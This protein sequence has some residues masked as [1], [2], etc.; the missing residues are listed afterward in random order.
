MPSMPLKGVL[1][2]ILH[3]NPRAEDQARAMNEMRGGDVCAEVH[4]SNKHQP[5][6][7][8]HGHSLML[9]QRRGTRTIHYLEYAHKY[10]LIPSVKLTQTTRQLRTATSPHAAHRPMQRSRLMTQ[11]YCGRRI[12][13]TPTACPERSIERSPMVKTSISTNVALTL[14]CPSRFH[15][16]TIRTCVWI[17]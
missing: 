12:S 6:M 14:R 4:D 3:A 13:R 8:A 1:E 16:H 2:E 5:S 11:R 9:S 17:T 7:L 15:N 10:S